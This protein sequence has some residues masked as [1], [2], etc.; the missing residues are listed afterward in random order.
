MYTHEYVLKGLNC[1][2]CAVKIEDGVKKIDEVNNATLNFT[3][4]KL[5]IEFSEKAKALK[6]HEDVKSL[7]KGIEPDVEI[8]TLDKKNS[9]DSEYNENISNMED[10]QSSK[11][12]KEFMLTGISIVL[13]AVGLVLNSPLWLKIMFFGATYLLTGYDVLFKAVKNISRGQLFDE[14]FLM[15]VATLGAFAIREF[16][17]AAAV[18]IFYKIGEIFQEIAVNNSRRSIKALLD[19]RPDYANLKK[20]DELIKVDPESVNIGDFIVV[21][22]GEKVPLDG[23]I[24]EG[25]SNV[26]TSAMTGESVPHSVKSGDKVLSGFINVSGVLTVKVEKNFEQSTVSKVLDLVQN[27]SS[28]KAHTENFITKFARYYTPA[29]VGAALVIAIVPPLANGSFDFSSWVY[30]ALI[31]LVISCPCALVVS[32]P[33]SFFGGIGGASRQGILIKGANYLEALNNIS[34]VVFD[35]TGTLTKGVF[36]VTEVVEYNDYST[37]NVLEYAALA[38]YYSSHPIAKSILEAYGRNIEQSSI[39]SYEEIPG[40]GVKAVIDGKTILAGNDRILHIDSCIDHNTCNIQGTIV[41]VAVDDKYAG[42]ILISDEPKHDAKETI[43]NLRSLGIS[44]IVMLTGDNRLSAEKVANSLGINNVY[45][46]LLPHEKVEQFE[47]LQAEKKV[48]NLVFVGDGVNDAPVIARADIGIAMGALGSDAAIEASDVVLMTDEPLKLVEAVKIARKTRKIVLQNIAFALGV[49]LI[50][51]ALGAG[52]VATMWEAVF[53]DVGVT[54]IAV[55]N[56]LR[57]M[58]APER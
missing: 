54:L 51:M 9:L 25:Y 20:E 26:D 14:N 4:Q 2:N 19:I 52:G 6:I 27:A 58:K 37:E 46:Q 31:F 57:A 16:P 45:A 10:T 41:H 12:K 36:K 34:T 17:E 24:V 23:V 1:A 55:L 50:V 21:K 35:K 22:P 8:I 48:G 3:S 5:K 33:L 18:M 49:K 47:K 32:I 28:K 39:E 53:A 15:S 43:S 13:F 38:E 30:R 29:V 56:S 7:V 44:N 42:Y 40:H 11:L